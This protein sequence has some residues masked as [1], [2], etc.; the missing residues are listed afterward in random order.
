MDVLLSCEFGFLQCRYLK[1]LLREGWMMMKSA[2]V[3]VLRKRQLVKKTPKAEIFEDETDELREMDKIR[4]MDEW[5]KG[6]REWLMG[7]D[8]HKEV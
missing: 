2:D 5:R 4:R 1:R 6:I 3:D 8:R 7:L